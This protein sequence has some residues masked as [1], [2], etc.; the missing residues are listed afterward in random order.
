MPTDNV[1]TIM[2]AFQEP[3]YDYIDMTG[4][5]SVSIFSN[6]HRFTLTQCDAYDGTTFS[7]NQRGSENNSSAI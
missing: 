7:S 6:E 3:Q 2:A 5:N 4:R 1:N